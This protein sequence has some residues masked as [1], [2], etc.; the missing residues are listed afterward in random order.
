MPL[1]T[2]LFAFGLPNYKDLAPTELVMRS[3][4]SGGKGASRFSCLLGI[5]NLSFAARWRPLRA[6]AKGKVTIQIELHENRMSRSSSLPA[7][8]SGRA[9]H[10]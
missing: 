6:M 7:M 3:C 5:M 10:P 1:L 2:E 9:P 8:Q 4:V